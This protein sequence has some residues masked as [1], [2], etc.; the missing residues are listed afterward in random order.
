MRR[1]RF[2]DDGGSVR[3]GEWTDDDVI[4]FGGEAY[5]PGSVDVLPPVEPTK[6]VC[7]AAN[8]VEHIKEAGRSIPEDLPPRP[9][10]FLKGPNAVAGHGDTVK[11]PTPAVT[12]EELA[13]REKG[14]IELGRGRIDYE[15]EFGVVIGEQC[16]NVPE[17]DYMDVVAGYTCVNDVSNRDDQDAERNWVRGKAFDTSAPL[18]PVLATPDEVPEQPRVRLWLNG[19]KRQD[20]D[21]DEL[22][23][24]VG[25]AVS[26]VSRFLTLEPGDV[27]AMGTTVGVGPLSDGDRVEIEVEGVGRL[28]H[29]VE[30]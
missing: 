15:G 8:Y 14:D 16:R 29:D 18:G 21:D 24:P 28:E 9:G 7:V 5:D 10:F 22:V 27:V 20:S 3:R 25:R 26:D 13:G 12:P 30:A 19:E 4:E 17:E 6:I 1:V 11:L 23:F 2:R